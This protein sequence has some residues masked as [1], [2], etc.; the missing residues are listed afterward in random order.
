MVT[1]DGVGFD[2][3]SVGCD[4]A[5]LRDFAETARDELD[6]V[7]AEGRIE[8]VRDQAALALV[9]GVRRQLSPQRWVFDAGTDLQGLP[10]LG[11]GGSPQ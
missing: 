10:W 1:D 11:L 7:E 2:V 8:V 3:S 5:R 4:N 6:V 9:V